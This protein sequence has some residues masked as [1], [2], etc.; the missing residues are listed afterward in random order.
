M[1][2]RASSVA[3]LSK[4]LASSVNQILSLYEANLFIERPVRRVIFGP[5]AEDDGEDTS[6]TVQPAQPLPTMSSNGAEGSGGSGFEW[7][8]S[9][10][11]NE[12]VSMMRIQESSTSSNVGPI[13]DKA[14]REILKIYDRVQPYLT[15]LGVDV[16]PYELIAVQLKPPGEKSDRLQARSQKQMDSPDN[17]YQ[18]NTM[19]AFFQNNSLQKFNL[20]TGKE[21]NKNGKLIRWNSEK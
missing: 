8:S 20:Y 12:T 4:S 9:F 10:E 15:K 5:S 14:S 19:M 1:V 11:A 7:T 21:T 3:R 17:N 16:N 2:R 13:R 18:F 6:P